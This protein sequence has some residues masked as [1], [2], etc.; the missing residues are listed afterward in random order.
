MGSGFDAVIAATSFHWLDQ[1]IALP[2]LGRT[3]RPGGW[4][5]IWWTLFSDPYRDDPLLAAATDMLGFEPGNQRTGTTFQLDADT[6]CQ[7]LRREAGL[8]DVAADLI[9]W[10][11]PMDS[12]RTRELFASLMTVRRLPEQDRARVLDTISDLVDDR[13][14]GTSIRPLLTPLYAGRRPGRAP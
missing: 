1:S 2:K 7:D 6:R 8:I 4:A 12:A 5:A 11:L 10:D 9:P 3:L 13:F 14:G